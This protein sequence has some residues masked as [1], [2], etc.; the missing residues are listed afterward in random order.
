MQG[1]FAA[2]DPKGE[3]LGS[4]G[5]YLKANGYQIKVF[6]LINPKESNKYNPF[7][8]IRTETDVIKLIT[9]LMK[10]TTPKK[11]SSSA[12]PQVREHSAPLLNS[13]RKVRRNR[14]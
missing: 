4:A 9:N 5:A 11:S 14:A 1:S 3:L 13:R 10:N 12:V 2:T 6:N 7:S 8:Y